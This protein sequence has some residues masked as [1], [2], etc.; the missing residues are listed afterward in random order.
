MN[1]RDT[2]DVSDDESETGTQVSDMA[3]VDGDMYITP[4]AS[5]RK[6]KRQT[7]RE[8]ELESDV[9]VRHPLSHRLTYMTLIT[10]VR[11]TFGF[12]LSPREWWSCAR[13]WSQSGRM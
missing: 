1:V 5:Q 11:L 9:Q 12:R 7:K 6:K 10:L 3:S 4:T 8:M 2:P 13:N